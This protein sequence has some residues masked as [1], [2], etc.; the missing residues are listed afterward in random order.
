MLFHSPLF[1]S[2]L[3]SAVLL[4]WGVISRLKMR[5][6]NLFLL[7]LS[8]FFYG[9]WDARFLLLIAFSTMVDFVSAIQIERNSSVYKKRVWLL[10]SLITNLGLLGIFKYYNFFVETFVDSMALLGLE[11]HNNSIKIILHDGISFYTFQTLSYTIDVYKKRIAASKNP[12]EFATFVSFFPQLV[13]GPIE[14]AEDLLEQFK[15][16]KTFSALRTKTGLKLILIG[17]FKKVVIADSAA[18]IA[19]QVFLPDQSYAGIT[20]FFGLLMFSIQIYAD[21]SGY[22]DMAR[23]IALLFGFRLT[24]N[25]H[26]PYFSAGIISFWQRWH[27]S[28]GRWFKDYVYLPLGGRRKYFVR[29]I[30]VVFLLSGLWHGANWTFLVWGAWHAAFWVLESH[31]QKRAYFRAIP[32]AIKIICTVGIV[33]LG[34]TWFRSPSIYF[35]AQFLFK[36]TDG[37]FYFWTYEQALI[38]W[39]YWIGLGLS[40]LLGVGIVFEW[41]FYSQNYFWERLYFIAP[42]RW[43][44][45]LLAGWLV[46]LNAFQPSPFIYFQF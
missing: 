1:L 22:S 25:F 40:C 8:Y 18:R 3:F 37:L 42:I 12:I 4:F 26:Y 35:A 46:V 29:N 31:L 21:F 11:L 16:Q 7:G 20:L 38:F 41:L 44:W 45:Y 2:L 30:W 34:W 6:Q 17:L 36:M 33:V 23:G 27:I 28:L 13:A 9:F 19:D 10:F 32:K 5:W 43:S 24:R 15:R 39:K 14:R